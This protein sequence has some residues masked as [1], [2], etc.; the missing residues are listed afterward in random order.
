MTVK[1]TNIR[2]NTLVKMFLRDYNIPTKKDIEKVLERL[3]HLEHMVRDITENEALQ[4]ALRKTRRDPK[5]NG[6]K[7]G[8][9]ADLV[10]D[11]LREHGAIMAFSDIRSK[12]GF[13]EKKLRN[14]IYR[15]GKAGRIDN[16]SRGFYQSLEI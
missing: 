1:L 13:P 9:D 4:K 14:I 2:L 6:K 12:T 11:I 10:A 7:A 3:D 16:T 15:L 5:L 8:A